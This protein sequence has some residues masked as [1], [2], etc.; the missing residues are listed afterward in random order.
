MWFSYPNLKRKVCFLGAAVVSVIGTTELSSIAFKRL[1]T[2]SICWS[3]IWCSFWLVC[4]SSSRIA[5]ICPTVDHESLADSSPCS[6]PC[7]RWVGSGECI[8]FDR[9]AKPRWVTTDVGFGSILMGPSNRRRS[10]ASFADFL[11]GVRGI[12]IGLP[13]ELVSIPS[14][15]KVELSSLSNSECMIWKKLS[16]KFIILKLLGTSFCTG[17]RMRRNALFQSETFQLWAINHSKNSK[18]PA[19]FYFYLQ[20]RNF[21]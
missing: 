3:I 8:H 10:D 5:S 20:A 4:L 17:K 21:T 18:N 7:G 15:D 9:V 11:G 1:S 14:E 2:S 19:K 12:M 13:W 6:G 16:S